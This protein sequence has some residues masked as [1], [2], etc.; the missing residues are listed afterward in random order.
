MTIS[1]L[2]D[3]YQARAL[4]LEA[5]LEE[6]KQEPRPCQSRTAASFRIRCR[7]RIYPRRQV[8]P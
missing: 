8:T 1:E 2:H 6:I 3:K 4:E 5:K 7:P